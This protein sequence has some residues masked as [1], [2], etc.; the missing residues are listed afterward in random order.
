MGTDA[1][2][3]EVSIHELAAAYALGVLEDDERDAFERHLASCAECLEEVGSLGD[4]AAALAFTLE[5]DEPSPELRGRIMAAVA[6]EPRNVVPFRRRRSTP[7]WASAAAAAAALAIGLGLW[8]TIGTS[9]SP[10]GARQVALTRPW[11]GTLDVSGSGVARLTVRNL[12]PAPA[13]R[14]YEVWVF[15]SHSRR[16]LPDTVFRRGGSKVEVRLNRRVNPGDT[17][18]VTVERKRVQ[19]PTSAPVTTAVLP[20]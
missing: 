14:L 15:R 20:A 6:A 8:A 11:V 7:V 4:A 16:A 17:V 3:D 9:S 18:A 19:A 5:G 10:S 13:G 12:A 1:H 2:R